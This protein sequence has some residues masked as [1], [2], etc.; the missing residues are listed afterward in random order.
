MFATRASGRCSSAPADARTADGV[1]SAARLI[2][3]TRTATPAASAERAA[4]Q[5]LGV[6]DAVE[7]DDDRVVGVAV[8]RQIPFAE[9]GGHPRIGEQSHD[10]PV[11]VREAIELPAIH[12]AERDPMLG[13]RVGQGSHALGRVHV[14]RHQDLDG[15]S[16]PDRL[17]DGP[18]PA[19]GARG[20]H[21]TGDQRETTDAI[22]GEPE[23]LRPRRLHGD[24]FDRYPQYLG[25]SLP[26]RLA[27]GP[28]RRLVAH[29]RQVARDRRYAHLRDDLDGPSQQIHPGDAGDAGV[30]LGEMH[31]DVAQ[32]HRAEQRIGQRVTHGVTVGVTG[33]ARDPVE[34]HPSE[35]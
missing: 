35:P 19:D 21:R 17:G 22:A 9:L 33:E 14:R 3:V 12:L 26:H 30:R 6:G 23:S 16:R 15:T 24:P 11:I 5:V 18:L 1:T 7:D 4:A 28:D 32:R 2:R 13:R 27:F 34:S 29:H 25:D 8:K 20:A 31:T 10:A